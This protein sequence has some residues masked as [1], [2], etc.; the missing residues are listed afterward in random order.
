MKI[1]IV[2]PKDSPQV[3]YLA[4]RLAKMCGGCTVQYGDGSWIHPETGELVQEPVALITSYMHE[5]E[6]ESLQQ[7]HKRLQSM[8]TAAGRNAN[9]HT[10]MYI[11][12]NTAHFIEIQ[13]PKEGEGCKSTK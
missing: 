4:S 2:F 7:L 1:Q 8:C 10:V 5:Q 12:D 11:V 13:P 9:E 6:D 3:Q